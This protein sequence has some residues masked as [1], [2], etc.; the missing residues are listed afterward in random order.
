[1]LAGLHMKRDKS[2]SNVCVLSYL[3]SYMTTAT[4]NGFSGSPYHLKM[5]LGHSD[6]TTTKSD[7][8]KHIVR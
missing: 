7:R 6:I 4:Q 2:G 3:H 1:M 5:Q 8:T